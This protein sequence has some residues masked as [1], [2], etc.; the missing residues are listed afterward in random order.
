METPATH[1]MAGGTGR[2]GVTRVYAGSG[3]TY[4]IGEIAKLGTNQEGVAHRMIRELYVIAQKMRPKSFRISATYFQVYMENVYDLLN[5]PSL[6]ANKLAL[7]EDKVLGVYVDG[8]KSVPAADAET[9]LEV[10]KRA[11]TNLKFASTQMNRHSSRSHAVCRLLVEIQHNAVAAKPP[12]T[13]DTS[14]DDPL[15]GAVDYL[16]AGDVR[17]SLSDGAPIDLKRW[18]RKSVQAITAKMDA[19]ASVAKRTTGILTLCD[20]AGSEDVGRSGE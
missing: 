8:A 9:C 14:M 17:P 16:S 3:K 7:R 10:L 1:G 5:E 11:S 20:L 13:P 6:N 12:L 15:G 4:T 19:V 2:A 18:R